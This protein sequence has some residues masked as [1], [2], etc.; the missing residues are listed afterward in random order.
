[1][2][3][4]S[5]TKQKKKRKSRT[6]YSAALYL[7]NYFPISGGVSGG[8][9]AMAC[10]PSAAVLCC[11]FD[12]KHSSLGNGLVQRARE[13]TIET[14]ET[15]KTMLGKRNEN[16]AN[17][18]MGHLSWPAPP[19]G[20][21]IQPQPVVSNSTKGTTEWVNRKLMIGLNC[22]RLIWWFLQSIHKF[23]LAWCFSET[24]FHLPSSR[25]L[26]TAHVSVF[27]KV[28]WD[29]LN[30]DDSLHFFFLPLR[31]LAIEKKTSKTMSRKKRKTIEKL[32]RM[33]VIGCD[34]PAKRWFE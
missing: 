13:R 25:R 24:F 29:L 15:H 27:Y 21:H 32:T 30:D 18:W 31:L 14:M 7:F 20:A 3:M 11:Q 28:I 2:M 9:Q 6:L 8:E 22:S 5:W 26:H 4:M 12:C 1:M 19:S 23:S 33:S 17:S 16:D 34:Y 10:M